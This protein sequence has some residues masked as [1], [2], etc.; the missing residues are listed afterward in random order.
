MSHRRRLA[1][2]ALLGFDVLECQ[3]MEEAVQ[4]AAAHPLARRCG[5]EIRPASDE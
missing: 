4:I 3:G 2:G 1:S 5:L